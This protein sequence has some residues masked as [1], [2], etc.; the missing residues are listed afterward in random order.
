MSSNIINTY[1]ITKTYK[2][3]SKQFDRV[4]ES[5]NPFKKE[6]HKKFYA[7][8]NISFN[9]LRGEVVGIIGKN[10]SGKSTLLKIITNVL[11][12]TSGSVNV[13]GKITA[14]LELGAGFNPELSGEENIYLSAS[15]MGFTKEEISRKYNEILDFSEI[16]EFINQP[17]KTYSSGM[18]ARLGFALAINVE[19][20]ILIVDEALS[21]G[22]VAFA[23]KCYAKIEHMCKDKSITVLFVSHSS[24][25]I[26]QLC[27]RAIMLHN[28]NLV[29]DG[30]AKDVVNL[31][32]KFMGSKDL[33]INTI[34]NEF[35]NKPEQ[36]SNIPTKIKCSN[37]S[38]NIKSKSIVV[39]EENG[40][41]ISDVK[42]TD[43]N[44]EE[45]N[46]L[47]FN[48]EYYYEYCVK[49]LSD[50]NNIKVAMFIKNKHGV[51]VSGKGMPIDK[52][53]ISSVKAG[54]KYIVRWKFKNIFNE[55]HYFF[56]AAVNS[57]NYGEKTILHRII[58]A[59]MVKSSKDFDNN[60]KGI[61]DLGIDLSI[62]EIKS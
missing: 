62:Q 44:N 58:D 46:I 41:C 34:K 45:C 30:K 40:A 7:L 11:T 27:T 6:Y 5:L 13:D 26:K 42:V 4:K 24:S 49:F 51:E 54:S 31:Y 28:G 33:D 32:D 10:G 61:I 8:N 25:V 60:S 39:Y 38:D 52:Y 56:N 53:K 50:F 19:P 57:T 55:G 20:E 29:I 47:D 21:V 14:L 22:D 2:L 17:I 1:E 23:R 36:T 12:P 59:Y 9:V 37:Y 15:I 35:H 16:G 18:K 43:L 3:Y 48:K